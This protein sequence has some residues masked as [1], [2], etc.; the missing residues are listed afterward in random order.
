MAGYYR[1]DKASRETIRDGWLYTGDLGYLDP[2]G[3]LYVLGRTK[4]LLIAADGEKYSPEGIEEALCSTSQYF[5]QMMLYNNQSPYTVA[6]LV[7]NRE[8][9]LRWMEHQH[10]LP[11]T[12]EGQDAALR[13][14]QQEIDAHR[15][16]GHAGG[17]FPERWL[18]AAIAVL[19]E[20]FTEQNGM[21]NSTLKIVRAR[22]VEA[23]RAR[24]DYLFTADG[25]NVNNPRNREVIGSWAS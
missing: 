1:N 2:D 17:T 20:G 14:L 10:F 6:L 12:P 19:A 11:G 25:K 4:S 5:D 8:A 15:P 24:I 13:M 3:Y 7:P 23:H 18:P 21:M 9:V 16:G 22:I